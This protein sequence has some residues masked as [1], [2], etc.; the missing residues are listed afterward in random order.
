MKKK[1]LALTLVLIM[2]ISI[3]GCYKQGEGGDKLQATENSNH[4]CYARFRLS[5]NYYSKSQWIF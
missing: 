3:V 1:F 4:W 5:S 2:G